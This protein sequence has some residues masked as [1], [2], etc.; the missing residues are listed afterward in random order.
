MMTE[1]KSQIKKITHCQ[2]DPKTGKITRRE[3]TPEEV[4]AWKKENIRRVEKNDNTGI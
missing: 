1:I 3:L 2:Y 4:E